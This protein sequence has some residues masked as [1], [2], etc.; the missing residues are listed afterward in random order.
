MFITDIFPK[1]LQFRKRKGSEIRPKTDNPELFERSLS[2]YISPCL[3]MGGEITI[4]FSDEVRQTFEQEAVLWE[5]RVDTVLLLSPPECQFEAEIWIYGTPN[6]L[7]C[8]SNIAEN[9]LIKRRIVIYAPHPS[10]LLKCGQQVRE[11]CAKK[12]D[13]ILKWVQTEL[14]DHSKLKLE[15]SQDYFKTRFITGSATAKGRHTGDS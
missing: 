5:R 10:S 6:E 15:L 11:S 8:A 12:L 4:L 3:S 2:K 9:C 7:R 13:A 1:R 14:I